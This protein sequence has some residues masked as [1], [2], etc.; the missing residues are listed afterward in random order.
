MSD[1]GWTSWMVFCR[2]AHGP[3]HGFTANRKRELSEGSTK[4]FE[5]RITAPPLRPRRLIPRCRRLLVMM[6]P[7][8]TRSAFWALFLLKH[9]LKIKTKN[10]TE[11]L[12]CTCMIHLLLA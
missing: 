10:C 12:I 5:K 3:P 11:I 6:L 7:R 9:F 1:S 4:L 2:T 8:V